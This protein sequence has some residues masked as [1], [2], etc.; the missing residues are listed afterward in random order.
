MYN[1]SSTFIIVTIKRSTLENVLVLLN[2]LVTLFVNLL[3]VMLPMANAL[4]HTTMVFPAKLSQDYVPL[5]PLKAYYLPS[6]RGYY[7]V[8]GECVLPL[9]KSVLMINVTKLVVVST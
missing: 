3:N 2:A 4:F 6:S 9:E 7:H 5:I 1:V 8:Q